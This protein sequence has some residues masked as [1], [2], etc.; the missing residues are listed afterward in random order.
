ME[1]VVGEYFDDFD[2]QAVENIEFDEPQPVDDGVESIFDYLDEK[3]DIF[4]RRLRDLVRFPTVTSNAARWRISAEMAE[5][6]TNILA[7]FA[8]KSTLL[9]IVLEPEEEKE[10][11]LVLAETERDPSKKTLCIYCNYDVYPETNRDFWYGDPFSLTL[12]YNETELF[13]KGVSFSKGPL[14]CVINAIGAYQRLCIEMPVN[15]KLVLDPFGTSDDDRTGKFLRKS[16]HEFFDDID[17]VCLSIGS[18][19]GNNRPCV[20]HGSRGICYFT[21]EIQG[22]SKDLHS[23]SYGGLISEPMTD[24][25]FMLNQLVNK[26]GVILVDD[27]YNDVRQMTKEMKKSLGK[28]DFNVHDFKDSIGAFQLLAK[29]NK[30]GLLA[31]LFYLPSLSIHG[32]EGAHAAHRPANLIPG[33][34]I[35]KFSINI[36]PNMSP[37]NVK[38]KVFDYLGKIWRQRRSTNKIRVQMT[39]GKPTWYTDREDSIC[40]AAR[41]AVGRVYGQEAELVVNPSRVKIAKTLEKIAKAPVIMLPV[42]RADDISDTGPEKMLIDNYVDRAKLYAAYMHVLGRLSPKTPPILNAEP[43]TCK[44]LESPGECTCVFVATPEDLAEKAGED[45][46]PFD[47]IRP[48]SVRNLPIT[49][50]LQEYSVQAERK[51]HE[52]DELCLRKAVTSESESSESATG[53]LKHFLA[54]SGVV[55]FDDFGIERAPSI[56]S[57]G[58]GMSALLK[59]IFP[60]ST[61]LCLP[62]AA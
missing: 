4:I 20:F 35:G 59:S 10:N 49:A 5:Y 57:F 1:S 60:R 43:C 29:E 14:L 51:I 45:T 8:M 55:G 42:G 58:G 52:L 38:R 50:R 13:G 19:L 40:V 6:L 31:N 47:D 48:E 54:E 53:H 17:F 22:P 46:I 21:I 12:N 37:P 62:D 27:I 18:W 39:V 56:E 15:V 3:R 23:G 36:V 11:F 30:V 26:Y 16:C 9:P 32:I 34:V 41:T 44:Y 33:K 2:H 7:K 61:G 25:V 24:L 28:L